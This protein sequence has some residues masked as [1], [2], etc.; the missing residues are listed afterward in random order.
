MLCDIDLIGHDHRSVDEAFVP[1]KRETASIGLTINCT[2]TKYMVADRDR[3]IPSGVGAEVVFEAD[4]FKVIEEFVYLG[5]LV[6]CD[7][8]VSREV[9][10]RIAAANGAF[11]GLL[12]QFRQRD[13]P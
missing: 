5:I 1:L 10:R 13:F 3:G 9:K 6:T 2:K 11:Y 4:V 7:N 12:N 8:D